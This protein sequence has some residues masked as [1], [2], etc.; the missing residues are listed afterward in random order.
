[1]S[2]VSWYWNE[3]DF[4]FR[5]RSGSGR[6][7]A[8]HYQATQPDEFY[9]VPSGQRKLKKDRIDELASTATLPR[10]PTV[11]PNP[12]Q[13]YHRD[14]DWIQTADG[15]CLNFAGCLDREEIDRREDRGIQRAIEF[16]ERLLLLPEP[17]SLT[18]DLIRQLH[19]EMMSEVYP[20][21]GE[22]RTV[23]LHKGD[24]PTKWPF[25]PGGI[26][27]LVDVFVRDV[28]SC[29]PFLSDNEEEVY[30]YVSEV[31]NE[32]LAIHPF[33]E[34]N[35]RLAFMMGNLLLMQNGLPPLK[36]YNRYRDER[37]YYTA[38]EAGRIRKDYK[39]LATLIAEWTEEEWDRWEGNDGQA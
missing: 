11:V 7:R 8:E 18:V 15:I 9:V 26:Q 3:K 27:P 10:A 37:R 14:W 34:G 32:I 25:P 22:W 20:F 28:L 5:F 12:W 30:A 29:S 21:A 17:A 24:G 2:P 38:C 39:P 4:G 6:K 13:N 19:R 16:I 31:M 1:M 35:G 33:R 23:D 36:V